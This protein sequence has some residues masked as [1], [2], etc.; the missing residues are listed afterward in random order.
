MYSVVAVVV[1]FSF[2]M[3]VGSR[4]DKSLNISQ[5]NNI[6]CQSKTR[7]T[8]TQTNLGTLKLGGAKC[9]GENGGTA[10]VGGI[11]SNSGAI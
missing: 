3:D 10:A 8:N 6:N 7:T 1:S 11:K 2:S 4:E 5:Q 9:T